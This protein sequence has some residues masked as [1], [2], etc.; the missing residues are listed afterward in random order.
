MFPRTFWS[1]AS[2]TPPAPG[3]FNDLKCSLSRFSS[4]FGGF[5]CFPKSHCTHWNRNLSLIRLTTCSKEMSSISVA[6]CGNYLTKPSTSKFSSV[7]N[8]VS[9]IIHKIAVWIQERIKLLFFTRGN[10]KFPTY[11]FFA[12]SRLTPDT[13]R[14]FELALFQ[15]YSWKLPLQLL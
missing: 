10:L 7:R 12:D 9:H 2:E 3:N 14:R 5:P 13:R 15:C 4:A 6:H 11:F 8:F 1:N